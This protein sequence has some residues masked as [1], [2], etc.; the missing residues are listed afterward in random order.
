MWKWWG[1]LELV[2]CSIPNNLIFL[3]HKNLNYYRTYAVERAA[4]IVSELKAT[5]ISGILRRRTQFS[6]PDESGNYS[7]SNP[8]IDREA[9]TYSCLSLGLQSDDLSPIL[10]R[11]ELHYYKLK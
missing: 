5:C 3:P 6:T 10:T 8:P 9:G 1:V 11:V 4:P 2:Q 7:R